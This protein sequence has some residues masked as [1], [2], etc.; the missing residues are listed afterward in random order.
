MDSRK[1]IGYAIIAIFFI[2]TVWLKIWLRKSRM[3]D[4]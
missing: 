3:K 2:A 4:K 1:F